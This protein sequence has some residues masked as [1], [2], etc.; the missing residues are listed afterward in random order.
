MEMPNE[1]LIYEIAYRAM[2][3]SP[4]TVLEWLDGCADKDSLIELFKHIHDRVNGEHMDEWAFAMEVKQFCS[5]VA[6]I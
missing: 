1:E 3:A 4:E 5:I 2:L 6:T